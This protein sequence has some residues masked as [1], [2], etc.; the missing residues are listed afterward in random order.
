[1][2]THFKPLVGL[3]ALA[4]AS[5]GFAQ[6]LEEIVVTAQKREQSLSDVPM[7]VSAVSGEQVQDAA[8][9]SFRELGAYVPNLSISENAVNTIISMRGIGVGAQQSFEQ[10][11]GVFVDGVHL[12]KSRQA[13]LG[14]FDLEQIEVLRGPQGILFGKNTLAGAMNIRSASPELGGS[15]EGRLALSME[16]YNGEIYEGWI[17]NSITDNFAIRFA[18]KDRKSDGFNNNTYAVPGSGSTPNAPT[19]DERIWRLSAKWEASEKTMV[20]IK[21]LESDYVRLGGQE[22]M[23]QFRQ[24]G[25]DPAGIPASNAAMYA[26]MGI[27]FPTFVP[28]PRDAFQDAKSLGGNLLDGSG[29]YGGPNE[30]DAGTNTKNEELSV[31]I[32]H[33]FDS[34]I[35][36][37]YVYGDSFYGYKDGIDAD[38]LPVQFIGRSDDSTYNQESHE[39]RFNGSIGDNVDWIGGFNFVDSEQKIDRLVVV[40][41]TLGFPGIMSAVTSGGLN[42]VPG[43]SCLLTSIDPT[44]TGGDLGVGNCGVIPGT[45]SFL[46]SDPVGVMAAV[47]GV[48]LSS[49]AAIPTYQAVFGANPGLLG[50]L[51]G[52]NGVFMA[53]Q[54]ARL[55]Y[56]QQNTQSSAA[57]LQG[58][59]R[60]NDAWSLTAGVRF[61]KEEKDVVAN[62]ELTQDATGLMNPQS[63]AAAPFLHGLGASS[64]GSYQHAFV[65]DR[66]TNQTIPGVTLQFEPNENSN[67]YLSYAEGFKSGGFNSVDDQNP[68]INAQGVQRN[69]PGPGF[70]YFDE[71]ARSIELGG[72]HTL[73]DGSMQLNWNIYSATY[74]DLQVST[75]V[76]L[77]FV[78]ANAA[79]AKIEGIEI[80][81]N[82]QVTEKLRVALAVAF[83]D[84]GYGSF[85]GAGCT[86][87]QQNG[88]N[89]LGITSSAAPV[90]EV[91]GCVQQFFQDGTPSGQSQDLAGAQIGTEYNGSAQLEYIQP[92][93]NN[94]VWFTQLDYNFT[95]DYFMTGDR[96]P[97]QIQSGFGTLNARTGLRTDNWMLMAYGRNL[98]DELIST[99]GYDIPLAQGSHGRYRAPGQVVGFQVA[100]EF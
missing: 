6:Q 70:E 30:R 32:E 48:P 11:V 71:T 16:D 18:M 38:F 65:E 27:A 83:N 28:N 31:S 81:M 42:A 63:P 74:N 98:T 53:N 19:T 77:G 5:T 67:Y 72:K 34:G 3:V 59:M 100:Y 10:S 76:G 57:F 62:V 66:S 44:F 87:L 2:K 55:S 25:L 82:Y 9:A 22:T 49:P 68:V 78:V 75:F 7:S 60:F 92:L 50:S 79:S 99:G 97:V 24:P 13:R 33:E 4:T 17:Q 35:T 8:I 88:L 73:L 40:D 96:D 1:M 47:T 61:T 58:T 80:D 64:F 54:F 39:L 91:D 51:Y 69:E 85:P 14:L 94:M 43:L 95:D 86:A 15:L 90:I 21:Y 29:G 20:N 93:S 41:G 26:I 89:A 37:N 45:P 36:M 23:H 52:A 46:A 12:G 84:G 56:W